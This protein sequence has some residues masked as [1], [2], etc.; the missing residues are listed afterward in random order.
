MSSEESHEVGQGT[1]YCKRCR[2]ASAEDFINDLSR[3]DFYLQKDHGEC[4]LDLIGL[5]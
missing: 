2:V 4:T 1:S 3:Y 5:A